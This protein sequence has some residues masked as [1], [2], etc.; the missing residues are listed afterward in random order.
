MYGEEESQSTKA[1]DKDY[2]DSTDGQLRLMPESQKILPP[3]KE[4][5]K[6]E[7]TLFTHLKQG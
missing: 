6:Q 7:S 3:K 5:K 2:W 1:A 4:E